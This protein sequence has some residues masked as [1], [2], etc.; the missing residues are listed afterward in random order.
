MCVNCDGRH[1]ASNPK[2]PEML[3]RARANL[4]RSGKYI[5]YSEALR[6]A[7]ADFQKPK[8][9]NAAH[10]LDEKEGE[11][12]QCWDRDVNVHPLND[13]SATAPL[14]ADMARQ[15]AMSKG[16][17]DALKSAISKSANSQN[18]VAKSKPPTRGNTRRDNLAK[19]HV[20]TEVDPP[21]VSNPERPSQIPK[22]KRTKPLVS[23]QTSGLSGPEEGNPAAPESPHVQNKA[24]KTSK[25]NP[26]SNSGRAAKDDN[27]TSI[28]EVYSSPILAELWKKHERHL[29]EVQEASSSS[30]TARFRGWLWDVLH[31]ILI[32]KSSGDPSKLLNKLTHLYNKKSSG[33]NMIPPQNSR[34]LEH[35][36]VLAGFRGDL[37]TDY[38]KL[39]GTF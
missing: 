1:S 22:E 23:S 17:K 16:Q 19:G 34:A 37:S 14:Y 32:A 26:V 21:Q 10:T 9:S 38:K 20:A 25:E 5:P 12:D 36:M 6:R 18:S 27:T 13:P 24:T 4:Y 31:A 11:P 29:D 30:Q 8:P 28:P 39:K 7:R 33:E 35:F 15:P 2:C 3:I